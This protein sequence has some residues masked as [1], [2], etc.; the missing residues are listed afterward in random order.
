MAMNELWGSS[1]CALRTPEEKAAMF[2]QS[3]YA[4]F[5]HWGLYSQAANLW[6]G[7][8]Y[9]GISEWM[10]FCRKVPVRAY[11]QLAREFNPV[12]FDAKRWV[13]IARNAGMRY[14]VIT[15]KHHEGFALFRSSDP[16]NVVDATPFG[17]D[18]LR[19]L[20]D[21]CREAGLG[22]GFYYSQFQDWHEINSWDPKDGAHDFDDYFE[23]KCLAQVRELLT[24]YGPLAMIWFDTPGDMTREQSQRIV[25]LMH[26]LQ[27]GALI[28]SRIGNGVGEYSTLGDHELPIRRIDGLWEAID[29][30]NDSWGYA[31]DDR[32]WLSE[33]E[34]LRRLVGV[35]ARGGNYM[36][37]V[38]PTGRG[39]IPAVI[40]ETLERAGEWTARH[41]D[42]VYG[43]EPSPWEMAPSWGDCTRRGNRLY[44]HIFDWRPGGEIACYGIADR[45]RQVSWNGMDLDFSAADGWLKIRLPLLVSDEPIAVLSLELT[46]AVADAPKPI[47]I[48]PVLPTVLAIDFAAYSGC[49]MRQFCWMEKFGEW[50]H[51]SALSDWKASGEAGWEIAL[52]APG[53]FELSVSYSFVRHRVWQIANEDGDS[54]ELWARDSGD[55]SDPKRFATF[56]VGVLE[57]KR[58]GVQR[59]VFRPVTGNDDDPLCDGG[60]DLHALTLRRY[61]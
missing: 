61:R 31:G 21:A 48:D 19:E 50:K 17:R 11:E 46:E 40:A 13:E 60:I 12:A 18:P 1:G 4:M 5:I 52:D 15:A 49:A 3:K 47:G 29:T 44:F 6:E 59:I 57:F 8:P 36:L 35:V 30:T 56:R 28:N 7:K 10:M 20:S 32:N 58:A 27:P 34:V 33:A 25:D 24:N 53:L 14:I 39:E 9:Y 37:N 45:V 41:A 55:G 22:F 51:K 38:G 2:R 42:A 23:R 26:E 16:F 54:L 43:V